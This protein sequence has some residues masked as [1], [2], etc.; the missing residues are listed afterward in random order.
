MKAASCSIQA[1]LKQRVAS[2][3]GRRSVA[4]SL[5]PVT[6]LI[7]THVKGPFTATSNAEDTKAA[8]A[9]CQSVLGLVATGDCSIATAAKKGGITRIHH[10]D[11]KSKSVL[12]IFAKFTVTV[13]GE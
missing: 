6:G 4:H 10:V 8:S 9:E 5:S 1:S 7:Y 3:G 11:L 13:Y 12:G 2:W